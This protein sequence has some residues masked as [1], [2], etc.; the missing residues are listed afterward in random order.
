MGRLLT[1][2]CL[3]AALFHSTAA[4]QASPRAPD[5]RGAAR[6]TDAARADR[7]Q[8]TIRR[9]SYGVAHIRA[10]DLPGLGFGEGYAQAEDHLCSIADQV[11]RARGERARY[12]GRGP[13]DVYLRS[14]IM[15]RGLRLRERG[16]AWHAAQPAE[17]RDWM[18]GYVAGYNRYLEETGRD[19]VGGWCQGADWVVPIT[20]DDLS[21]YH[22]LVS[23]VAPAFAGAIVAARPP[24]AGVGAG[25]LTGPGEVAFLPPA[26]LE[27]P[28]TASNGWALGRDASAGG[29][30]MLLANPH[31]PWTGA[32]RFWEKHLTIPGDL[33]AYGVNLLGVPGVGIGFNRDVA[34]T[35]TSSAGTRFTLYALDLVP[36]DPTR[37]RYGHDVRAMTPVEV[38][39]PVHGEEAPVR[40][41]V[42]HTHYGPAVAFGP[43]SWTDGRAFALRDA[44]EHL[45]SYPSHA[46]A[47]NRATSLAELQRAH[48]EFQAIPGFNT[49]AVGADGVAWYI[50]ASATPH[51]GPDVLDR[52]AERRQRDPL[53]GQLWQGQGIVLLDGSNPAD[54]W[55]DDPRARYPGIVPFEALP[56]LER[57]DYVF[58]ANDSY[59]LAHANPRLDGDYSPL[60]GSQRTPVSLRTRANALHLSNARPYRSAGEDGRFT[61]RQVQEAVLGNHSLAADLLVPELVA[62][63]QARPTVALD[64]GDVDLAAACA[65]LQDWD[66]RLDLDSRGAVLFREWIG[67]YQPG[68]LTGQGDLFAVDFDPEDPLH[69]PRELAPG[70]QALENLA[71][72][73][74][75]LEQRGLALDVPL[76]DLQY[77]PSKLPRRIPIHG[78]FGGWE[79]VLNMQQGGA[80][81]TTLEPVPTAPRVDGSRFLTQAG[82]PALHGTS[83]LLVVE[84][85]DAGP[86]AEAVLTYGQSGDPASEHFIDQTLLYSRKDWRLVRFQDDEI[87]R[88]IRREYT[89]SG[90]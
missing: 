75:L 83:F 51:L 32:N 37:Y 15:A 29:G 71:R 25:G 84:Y 86:Q 8:A 38:V 68:D 69:T 21:A 56:Q 80:S 44:T 79:G 35:H 58:N 34:W 39:V 81:R 41:T 60:H 18:E 76:G 16:A 5:E 12:F 70:P 28:S 89:V 82:Y 59:W 88:D 74:R 53:T 13:D 42:W 47:T 85:T 36:G 90:S 7:Y 3:A 77:A 48:A 45:D 67:Q 22:V 72:A 46:L 64:D 62:R 40:H 57:P 52:W 55:L 78:G 11:V 17:A 49:V 6:V 31:Y 24:R 61:R 10:A 54:E 19:A 30:G 9:T 43:L 23:T 20:A 66:R 14:D 87:R 73:V 1:A 2:A 50:D 27:A 65:V 4:A 63:C 33:D 26:A